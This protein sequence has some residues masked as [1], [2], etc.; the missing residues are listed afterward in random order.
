MIGIIALLIL[1]NAILIDLYLSS[2]SE[3]TNAQSNAFIQVNEL[4]ALSEKLDKQNMTIT[5][6][7]STMKNLN[8]GNQNF[9]KLIANLQTENSKQAKESSNPSDLTPS[10]GVPT[11]NGT[12]LIRRLQ[13]MEV[14]Q[15]FSPDWVGV[16]PL[17][18]NSSQD[19]TLSLPPDSIIVNKTWSSVY[20]YVNQT[21]A[22]VTWLKRGEVVSYTFNATK[23]IAFSLGL[24]DGGSYVSVGDVSSYGQTCRIP[25]TGVYVFDFAIPDNVHTSEYASVSFRCFEVTVS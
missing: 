22:I 13:F 5:K 1:T 2:Q 18:D 24:W 6:I 4:S 7:N 10:L 14:D 16:S 8:A 9:T 23:E 12:I 17:F 20:N 25:V 15:G 3:K 11:Q 21:V 19:L